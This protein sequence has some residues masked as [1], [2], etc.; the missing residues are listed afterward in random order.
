VPFGFKGG[1]LS[2]LWQ[3][4]VLLEGKSAG[5]GL[6][7]ATQSVLWSDAEVFTAYPECVGNSMMFL[8]TAYAAKL[9]CKTP[10]KT[11]I[12]LMERLL[13]EIYKYAKRI[14]G[15]SPLRQTF[16]FNALVAVDNAAWM[17]YCS[18]ENIKDFSAMIPE[19]FR[20]VLSSRHNSLACIPLIAYKVP[21]SEV[22]K[23]VGDGSCL[24][25]IK[26]GSDPAGDGS[27]EK[28]LEWDKNRL[29]EIHDA[30][31]NLE[32]PHTESG[33][34][35][36][37][38]DANGRYEGKETLMRFLAHAEKIGA[39]ERIIL[40]EEPFPEGRKID[41]RKIPVSLA[42]DEGA[43]TDN[44]ARKLLDMGYGAIVLKPIAKTLSMSL[45]IAKIAQERGVPCLCADLTVNPILVDWNKNVAARIPPLPG[46]KIGALESNGHQ[47]YQ[48]WDVMKSYHPHHEAGW[49][50][51]KNGLF[52]LDE[53]FYSVSGGIFDVS[54]HYLNLLK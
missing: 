21:M 33:H 25:K 8:A 43:H 22:V 34:V 26:I 9:A 29:S 24:L 49:T 36:Y 54:T 28:M 40:F 30:V 47:N 18:A 2:E 15:R 4:A 5:S 27:Q 44:E 1:Y 6:G 38:L 3:T 16:A 52:H 17:Q 45:K 50:Q 20:S 48:N 35:L 7:L 51:I 41:I 32:T 10:W 39:L 31:K 14:T 53:D 23:A 11:P 37:Y 42:A 46:M 13:P 12:E 19:E